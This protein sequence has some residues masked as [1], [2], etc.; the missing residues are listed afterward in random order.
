M[1]VFNGP[2][3]KELLDALLLTA[4]L[5]ASGYLVLFLAAYHIHL[6]RR[7]AEAGLRLAD[8]AF[9]SSVQGMMITDGAGKVVRVNAAF[10]RM[11][12]YEAHEAVG[13]DVGFFASARHDPEFFA[14]VLEEAKT[15]GYW[16]GELSARRRTGEEDLYQTTVSS[17]RARDGSIAH[18]A[19]SF[20]DITER[21]IAEQRIRHLAHHDLLTDLPNRALLAERTALAIDG[22]RRSGRT[23]ALMFVDLDRFKHVNDS[24]GHAVGDELLRRSSR[25]LMAT[26][27]TV[28]VVGRQG[29]DEFVLLLPEVADAE[30]AARVALK[31]V[32]AMRQPFVLGAR[33]L[34]VSCSVGIALFPQ[35][36]EDFETLMRNADTAM[37]AAKEAGRD[38]YRFHAA[39]MTRRANERLELEA[40]LR[41]ALHTGGLA[42]ALQPQVT[43]ADGK[44]CGME[45]LVRWTHPQRGAISPVQ[46]IPV[47]EDCGL[48]VPLGEWMLREA[49]RLRAG[50]G[51]A[52]G[53]APVAVN[54]SALQ[55]RDPNFVAMVKR[56]MAD[57]ALPPRL[58]E[59][60]VTESVI[61][62]GFE[63]V[64]G[65]L[66]ELDRMGLSLSVDDFGTGYSSLSY[67][68]RL[69]VDKLKIDR[70]FVIE[71][72]AD[73]DS[74]AIAAAVVGLARG[75]DM[76]VI[77]EGVE[78]PAQ[79]EF[80]HGAGCHEAQGYLYAKPLSTADFAARYVK[81]CSSS[82]AAAA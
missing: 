1:A 11:T 72:P 55:F 37:Y 48:I 15:Q 68:K 76:R 23:V 62:G 3:G 30:A 46:F 77:A 66:D 35:N 7:E 34:L 45:A 9:D 81:E 39:E 8:A 29:G 12:R 71:L 57:F 80:L 51:A 21:R 40:D 73:P 53:E 63:Q 44:L 14:R 64:K 4:Y 16:E 20:L 26:L 67:L 56:A 65:M 79:A 28:D 32:E 61:M 42:L 50:W 59:L 54:V 43:L 19:L 69:P 38:C 75:L 24:L 49:C 25:R 82:E 78:T 52:L 33:E 58:L 31:V 10:S 2:G 17:V 47:A 6:K 18:Y 41:H 70:S 36:G 22:A 27:R 74:R 5:I 60:E 13:R